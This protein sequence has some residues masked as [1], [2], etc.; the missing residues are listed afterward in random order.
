M[1]LES[2][3]RDAEAALTGGDPQRAFSA[4]RPALRFPAA[5]ADSAAWARGLALLA[6]IG[7]AIAGPSFAATA[8][9]AAGEPDNPKALFDLGYLLYEEGLFDLAAAALDRA[10]GLEPAR[11]VILTELVSAL[12]HM[13]LNAVAR[14]RLRAAPGL[15]KKLLEGAGSLE[16]S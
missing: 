13:G 1:E 6:R 5:P 9:A 7:G 15:V 2:A 16:E 11:A 3:L 4:L 12:E 8:G 10:H 14:D